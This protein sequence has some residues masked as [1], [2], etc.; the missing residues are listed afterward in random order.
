MASAT[1][2]ETDRVLAGYAGLGPDWIARSD[3]LNCD[4]IYAP[5]ADL[6]PLQPSRVLDLGAAT[7]RDAAWL[8]DKGHRVTAV[9]PVR[10]LSEA[11]QRLHPHGAIDW[12]DDRLPELPRLDG[13][14]R[15]DCVLANG[16]LHHL[17]PAAQVAA[18]RRLA[19]LVEPGGVLIVSL[20]H[21]DG[22]EGRRA[23]PIDVGLLIERARGCGLKLRRRVDKGS[24][25]PEN[26]AAGIAWT[27]LALG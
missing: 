11:G 21:G 18:I 17:E 8:A 4:E 3:G 25:Q 14:E 26:R 6:L 7:G 5:V 23:W 13:A 22:P 15:Y 24:V 2:T 27:W 20:R 12:I 9:E 16:V 19:D 1:E 10:R